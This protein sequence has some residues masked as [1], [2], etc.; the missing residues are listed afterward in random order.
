MPRYFFHVSSGTGKIPDTQGYEFSCA[1][2]ACL[3][4]HRIAREAQTYLDEE[5]GRWMVHITSEEGDLEIIVLFP[6]ARFC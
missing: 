6:S 5:D 4:A 2:R 1:E 3:Y